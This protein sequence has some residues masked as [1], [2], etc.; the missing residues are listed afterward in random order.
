MPRPLTKVERGYIENC[1]ATGNTDTKKIAKELQGVG[2]STVQKHIDRF[3]SA[4]E[5]STISA[6]E[7]VETPDEDVE[8]VET[9][10]EDV[11]VVQK[12]DTNMIISKKEGETELEHKARIASSRTKAGSL[13]ARK[14]GIAVM[15]EAASEMADARKAFRL[16]D[17]TPEQRARQAERIHKPFHG[18]N[19][20]GAKDT[21]TKVRIDE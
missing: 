14:E 7:V 20:G 18:E 1:V 3:F 2:P 10:D 4:K 15:T 19:Q 6:E 11:E 17:T 8:S 21:S 5:L 9:P 12:S 16:N 13:I